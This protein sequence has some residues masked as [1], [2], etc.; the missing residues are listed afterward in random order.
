MFTEN[1]V[2]QRCIVFFAQIDCFVFLSDD[3]APNIPA[4]RCFRQISQFVQTGFCMSVFK[5]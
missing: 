4:L 3:Y 1:M 2:V 5:I